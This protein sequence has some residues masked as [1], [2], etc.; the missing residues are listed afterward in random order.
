[1]KAAHTYQTSIGVDRQMTKSV[2]ISAVYLNGRGT[3][4]SR[5]RDINAPIGGLYPYG[6]SQLRYL[7]ESTGF[8]RTNQIQVI[9]QRQLQEAVPVRVLRALLRAD[10]RGRA[11]GGPVQS[12]AGMGAVELRRRAAPHGGGH[13]PAA[14]V[15]DLGEPV[16][17]GIERR[18]V[19]HHDGARY[20]R[21]QHYGGASVDCGAGG[22]AVHGAA[23]YYYSAS[24]GCFN[25][26]PAAGTSIGRNYAR[27]PGAFNMSMRVM[28]TW[29]IGG[30]G[31]APAA[32]A[33]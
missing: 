4:L 30:K 18:A 5:S 7:T 20:E 10:G 29:T 1:M 6:D 26:N 15:E 3:H 33:A 28:R 2:K 16:H 13:Q 8:S 11:G 14:A 24:F 12:A 23:I 27:G 22:G 17:H 31:E 32:W 9:A 25:L 19:Q 21:R